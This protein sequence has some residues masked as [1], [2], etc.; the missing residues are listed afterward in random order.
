MRI[1]RVCCPRPEWFAGFLFLE[2]EKN[3]KDNAETQRALSKSAEK[4]GPPRK[5]IRGA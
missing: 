2:E 4:S 5:T 1:F 3:E